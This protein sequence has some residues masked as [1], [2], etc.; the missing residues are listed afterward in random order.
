MQAG[1]L[2]QAALQALAPAPQRLVDG[3]RRRGESALQDGEGEA[4]GA[5]APVV[6]EGLGAV[7]LAAHV[8]GDRLVQAGLGLGELVRH[9]VGDA[10]GE[11]GFAVELEQVLLHHA[12]HQVRDIDLARALAEAALEAVAV[13]Q[14]EEELEVLLLA[15]VGRGRH[16]Q[17]VARQ[18]RQEPAE[19]VAPGVA[20]LAAEERGRHL[21]GLVADHQVVAAVRGPELGLDLL[22][23]GELVQPRDG[24]VVLQEP[25]ARARRLQLVVGEDVEGQAEAAVELVLP[26]LHQAAGAD[27]EAALQIPARDQLL[28][29]QAGHDRLAGAGVVGQQ[30]AQRLARQHGLVHGRDLVRQGIHQGGVHRED[31]IEE[32]G[33]ADAV[34]LADEAVVGAVAVEAPGA[35][36]LDHLQARLVLAVEDL[37]G[38]AAR[39]RAVDQGQRLGAVPLHVDDLRRGLREQ[40]AHGGARLEIFQSQRGLEVTARIARPAPALRTKRSPSSTPFAALRARRR[41]R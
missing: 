28:D 18:A 24:Q 34:R 32:M 38:D 6:L 1:Q 25:V 31:G 23:A 35:A 5:R 14:G 40:A 20:H 4:D 33:Q 13:E 36:L 21:V 11:Q 12:P 7:E 15:V 41:S 27:H 39:G 2:L 8:L 30:E 3:L 17:E 22:V 37:L 16:Q 9:R 29:E 26:L 10:L 19:L